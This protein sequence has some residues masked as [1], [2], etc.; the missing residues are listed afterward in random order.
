MAAAA[1]ATPEYD[2][3]PYVAEEIA[4]VLREVASGALAPAGDSEHGAPALTPRERAR[5]SM[6]NRAAADLLAKHGLEG[7]S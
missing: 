7:D 2:A 5:R 3:S 6:L 1:R 4:T